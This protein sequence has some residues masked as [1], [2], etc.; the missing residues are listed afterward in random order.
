MSDNLLS[1]QHSHQNNVITILAVT[2]DLSPIWR[3]NRDL[4]PGGNQALLGKTKS[5]KIISPTKFQPLQKI[6]VT[7]VRL[8]ILTILK[9]QNMIIFQF[10]RIQTVVFQ[11][12][13]SKNVSQIDKQYFIFY[14]QCH[15]PHQLQI[16][17]LLVFHLSKAVLPSSWDLQRRYLLRRFYFC[18]R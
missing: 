1:P 10:Y 7:F 15:I 6:L 4:L 12:K 13:I 17:H 11:G 9:F 5:D 14:S 16:C 18:R 3:Q 2:F 8:I